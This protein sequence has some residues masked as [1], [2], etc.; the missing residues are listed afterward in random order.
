MQLCDIV[1]G[2]GTF[3]LLLHLSYHFGFCFH[4]CYL[5]AVVQD[6]QWI[7]LMSLRKSERKRKKLVKAPCVLFYRERESAPKNPHS[8][9]F[10]DVIH[11]P[12]SRPA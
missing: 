10:L 5:V 6:V 9:F 2:L 3:H 8:A 7:V 1:R 11:S 12:E 4:V